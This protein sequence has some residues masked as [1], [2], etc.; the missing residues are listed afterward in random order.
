L[1]AAAPP[2]PLDWQRRGDAAFDAGRFDEAAKCYA[3]AEA[4]T[5]EPGRVAYNAGVAN[6]NLGRY[7]EAERLFRCSLESSDFAPKSRA[8]Y[9]LGTCLLHAS[10]GRD[11]HR[12]GEAIQCFERTL[13]QSGL[14]ESGQADARHNLELAKLLWRR[15][16]S[17]APPPESEPGNRDNPN[18]Q[19]QPDQPM[20]D[21]PGTE[22]G[23]GTTGRRVGQ[24]PAGPDGQT[25]MQTDKQG[26]PGTG[27]M[28][29]ISDA[30]QQN[31]LPPQEARALLQQAG[32]RIRR[33]RRTLER[34]ML[35]DMRG[36][37]DW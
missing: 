3:Q 26:A 25:P 28:S 23:T 4:R 8:W 37:P 32:E 30:E 34:S 21:E 15:V 17:N 27:Q 12:L 20:G 10:D 2:S 7:R 1:L 18:T 9:N 36:Y 14:D 29:P 16:N 19:E 6:F 24:V 22:P 35:G 33:E 11:A 31:P 5:S 13:K